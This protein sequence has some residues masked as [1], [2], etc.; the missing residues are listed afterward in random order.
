[1]DKIYYD[2][3]GNECNIR[4]MVKREPEWSANRI[5]GCEKEIEDL[6]EQLKLNASML[7]RQYDLAREATETKML[8]ERQR[9]L[10]A[11]D[12]E[13]E[14]TKARSQSIWSDINLLS[15]VGDWIGV[16]EIFRAIVRTTKKNIRKR[17]EE[18]L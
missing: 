2:L 13:P 9:C 4:Q 16:E 6:K 7:A 1:M 14:L 3:D 15:G 11:V 10:K 17:I 8:A 5:Q 18:G 12:D